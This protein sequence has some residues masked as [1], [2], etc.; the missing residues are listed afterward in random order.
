MYE[1][2]V[3]LEIEMHCATWKCNNNLCNRDW[4]LPFILYSQ[5]HAKPTTV[6]RLTFFLR[7]ITLWILSIQSQYTASV[8]FHFIRFNSKVELNSNCCSLND[9]EKSSTHK[10]FERNSAPMLYCFLDKWVHTHLVWFCLI[11]MLARSLFKF[12]VLFP[13]CL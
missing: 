10:D 12:L 11:Q 8:H 9:H 1:L 7:V 5:S 13:Y 6:T 2:Y 3:A 4:N